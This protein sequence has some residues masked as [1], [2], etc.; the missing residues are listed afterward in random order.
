MQQT[1]VTVGELLRKFHF[2]QVCGDKESLNRVVR[3]NEIN[4]PGPEILGFFQHTSF[5]RLHF[6]GHKEQFLVSQVNE[7][8]QRKRFRELIHPETPAII[9]TQGYVCPPILL[10]VAKELNFPILV[11]PEKTSSISVAVIIYL[12]ERLAPTTSVHGSLLEVLGSGVLLLG[13]SGIGKSEI[14]LELIKRGHRL[15]ADD[16]VDLVKSGDEIIGQA[17]E[18]LKGLIEVRGIGL[19]NI[20]RMFGITALKDRQTLDY[21]IRLV[22]Y[23]PNA[24]YDR[25]GS[26][27]SYMTILDLPC[28][29]IEL[30]VTSGRN[31]ADLVEVAVVNMR[32]K[33]NGF[34]AT[35]EFDERFQLKI[36][37]GEKHK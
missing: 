12:T 2:V 36:A 1:P 3:L 34:D 8:D 28:P 23:N 6:I 14:A 37:E 17:P 35:R 16:R 24:T 5:S 29:S 26:D 22:S 11:T 21:A 25:L 27:L 13:E 33:E 19:I 4:R 7:E 10:E 20:S 15:V 18:I 9:I 30:P 31:M 32:L